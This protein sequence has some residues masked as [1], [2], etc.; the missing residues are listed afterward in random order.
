MTSYNCTNTVIE[1]IKIFAVKTR[2]QVVTV[3]RVRQRETQT[4]MI[5]KIVRTKMSRSCDD[6]AKGPIDTIC[7]TDEETRLRS[8]SQIRHPPRSESI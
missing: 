3:S 4:F 1:H 6:L 8:L 7:D 2:M 5:V